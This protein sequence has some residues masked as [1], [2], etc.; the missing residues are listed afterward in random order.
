MH[1]DSQ[2]HETESHGEICNDTGIVIIDDIEAVSHNF[3]VSV[4][5]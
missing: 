3:T 2:Q 4:G 5:R 1:G